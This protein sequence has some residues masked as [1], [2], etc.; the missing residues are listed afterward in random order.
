METIAKDKRRCPYRLFRDAREI[1]A[2]AKT[3]RLNRNSFMTKTVFSNQKGIA[4]VMVLIL[5][6]VALL[7]MAGLIYMLT[8]GTQVS[9]LQ[10]RYETASEA[11]LGGSDV[12]YQLIG[13]RGDTS[14]TNS[15]VYNDMAASAA[16]I[17]TPVTCSGTNQSGTTFT[18]IAAKLNT[19]TSSWSG[20]CNSATVIDPNTNTTYDMVFTLGTGP[21]YNVY[22]KIV[23]TVEGN[24]AGDEGLI[25]NKVVD[26]NSGEI[27]VM[28]YPYV[29]TI[30]VDAENAGNPSE[31]AKYSI[32]YL[33]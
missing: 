32:L 27:K 24:S 4:L 12:T 25:N 10:K 26:S 33:Y 28:S 17:T 30:E 20:S 21:T 19:P 15:F 16:A 2:R 11:G 9:G 22:S 5:S 1:A 13:L 29:Y 6:T 7:I 8:T 31:R 23:D 18:W 14:R 3:P